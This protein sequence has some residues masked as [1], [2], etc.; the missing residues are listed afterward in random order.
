MEFMFVT[1]SLLSLASVEVD[2]VPARVWGKPTPIECAFAAGEVD[3]PIEMFVPKN[4]H[5]AAKAIDIESGSTCLNF[6]AA[7]FIKGATVRLHRFR[8]GTRPD[9]RA[10]HWEVIWRFRE[11]VVQGV[12]FDPRMS[13][14]AFVDRRGLS[15][16]LYD[17]FGNGFPGVVDFEPGMGREQ[18]GPRLKLR[19]ALGDA[20]RLLGRVQSIFG[21]S[22]RARVIA[23]RDS[24][25]T[26]RFEQSPNDQ[27]SSKA[28]EN[29][30]NPG[31]K[32]LLFGGIRSPYLGIQ[33]AGI[34]IAAGGFSALA[35]YGLFRRFNYGN[36]K[37]RWTALAT[38]SGMLSLFFWG[39]AWAGNPL[40]AWGFAQ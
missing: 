22:S 32:Y 19:S 2:H 8:G 38:A 34:V 39:W 17:N 28:T 26:P 24:V 25:G 27:K 30:S 31:R 9:D 37:W 40:S 29:R 35:G 21:F 12:T 7:V 33:I 20:G 16:V 14:T 1:V 36:R 6:G 5:V 11:G 23:L 18:I 13:P 10:S 3:E 4:V 15:E